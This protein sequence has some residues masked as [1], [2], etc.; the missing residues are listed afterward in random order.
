MRLDHVPSGDGLGRV[1]TCPMRTPDD[2]MCTR[3]DDVA[4]IV[5]AMSTLCAT[6][7]LHMSVKTMSRL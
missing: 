2:V 1:M 4:L 5:S 6:Q 7:P 3:L